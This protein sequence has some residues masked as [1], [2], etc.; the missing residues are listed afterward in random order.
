MTLP[1][2]QETRDFL[3]KLLGSEERLNEQIQIFLE[4]KK[5]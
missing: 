3:L 5:Q 2:T 1:I 4:G